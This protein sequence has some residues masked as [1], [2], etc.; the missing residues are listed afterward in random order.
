MTSSLIKP[1]EPWTEFALKEAKNGL[2]RRGRG[3][4]FY[5]TKEVDQL[6]ANE[7]G[8]M[9]ALKTE[10]EDL[11]R[12]LTL[13]RQ[14]AEDAEE[15]RSGAIETLHIYTEKNPEAVLN[16]AAAAAAYDRAQ[17]EADALVAD[18]QAFCQERIAD[19]QALCDEMV[20]E[21]ARKART[22]G[23]M[24]EPEMGL[25]EEEFAESWAAWR[26]GVLKYLST[27]ATDVT[28]LFTTKMLRI[29]RALDRIEDP[30]ES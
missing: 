21:A 27:R 5:E 2:T 12:Q 15:A 10:V 18:T 13:L 28:E 23:E 29:K 9:R 3:S 8:A 24:D 6:L 7:L 16:P 25:D 20:A 1:M 22:I 11:R 17:V 19:T 4:Q 30:V 26:E 14:R